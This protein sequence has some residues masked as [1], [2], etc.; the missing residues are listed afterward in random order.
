MKLRTVLAEL[1]I[2]DPHCSA[3]TLESDVVMTS[4]EQARACGATT[5]RLMGLQAA[6]ASGTGGSAA[7][8]VLVHCGSEVPQELAGGRRGV[9]AFADP[10]PLAQLEAA[11]A[12]LPASISVLESR[13]ERLF[14]AFRASYDLTQ[15]AQRAYEVI[16]NPL[17]V[18]NADRRLLASAGE[19][20]ADRQDVL[21]EITQGYISEEV[22]AQLEADGIID[23]VRRAHHAIISDNARFGQRWVTSVISYHHLELGR[24]DV[25]ESERRISPLDL[26]LIDL[27]SS[28]AGVMI[29]RLGLSGESAGSGSSVLADMLSNSFTNEKTMRAQLSLTG[30]PLDDTYVL[31]CVRGSGPTYAD[32]QRRVARLV[33]RELGRCLWCVRDGMV[34]FMVPLGRQRQARGF[35]GY[36]LA[37]RLVGGSESL[38]RSFENNGLVACVAEPFDLLSLAPSRMSQCEALTEC[39]GGTGG[40]AGKRI[41]YFWDLRY[42]AMA[43]NAPSFDKVDMM[44]DKRVVAMGQYDEAHG[45]QYL[46]TAVMSVRYPGSPAEVAQVL[47]IHRNTYFY[48]VNKIRELFYLDLKDGNDRLAVGFSARIISGM[49]E[50]LHVE[51]ERIRLGD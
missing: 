38:V 32:Y 47:S 18:V 40:A 11:F 6:K 19:F 15:F 7:E 21:D 43:A 33:A 3:E 24:F 9:V 26:E 14:S 23:D 36:E 13:R 46:E 22:N 50:R 16:G 49:G 8:I 34:F 5:V 12:G 45:T 29:D 35:D 37:E 39:I 31:L 1:G 20:P 27:G 51:T 10:R 25:L 48:R 42:E 28:L 41:L 4:V 17:M 2:S 44:L 30:M